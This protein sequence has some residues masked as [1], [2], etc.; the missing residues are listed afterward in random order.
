MNRSTLLLCV[1]VLLL[2]AAAAAKPVSVPNFGRIATLRNAYLRKIQERR[3]AESFEKL[4]L[5]EKLVALYAKEEEKFD[6][7]PLTAERVV[8]ELLAWYESQGP[9][10]GK[11]QDELMT[12]L[13]AALGQRL[14]LVN[15]VLVDKDQR[16][17]ASK[18]LVDGLMHKLQPV[19]E[20][21]IECLFRIY[22]TRKLYN[23]E[24]TSRRRRT[25]QRDWKKYIETKR[26][27]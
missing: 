4:P 18:P 12:R 10:P 20:I 5:Q 7:K 19:R 6:G 9:N 14:N 27:R 1:T 11:E 2:P 26:R 16:H 23:P 21:S 8:R 15:N 24:A 17:K 22:G 25:V 13:A 3:Q